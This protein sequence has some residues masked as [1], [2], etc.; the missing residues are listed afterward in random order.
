MTNPYQSPES[1][2]LAFDSGIKSESPT[3][4]SAGGLWYFLLIPIS[5]LY[6]VGA[7]ELA[8][9]GYTNA[10][11]QGA[12]VVFFLA[13]LAW[14]FVAMIVLAVIRSVGNVHGVPATVCCLLAWIASCAM[15]FLVGMK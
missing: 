12:M 6:T 4:R 14:P 10:P 3:K 15:P 8:G 7:R 5:F 2:P 13:S 1:S 9:P 11:N